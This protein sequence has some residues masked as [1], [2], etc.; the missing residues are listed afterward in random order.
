[1]RPILHLLLFAIALPAIGSLQ[2]QP[3][4]GDTLAR[5]DA[6]IAQ[7]RADWGVPGLAVAIVRGDEVLLSKGYGSL[8]AGQ[9][10][11]VDEHTLFAIA[12]NSKAFTAAALAMLADEGKLG[13]DDHVSDYL[14]WLK[15]KDPWAT[16]ELR[17]RDLLCHRSGLGTFS[18]DLL[19]WGTGYSAREVLE[20]AAK[21]EPAAPFRTKYEYSNLMFIAAGEVVQAASGLSWAEFVQQRIFAPLGMSRSIVSTRDLPAKGNYATPHKTYPG[22]SQPIAWMGWD[23]MGAAGGIISSAHDM[24]SW[25]QCQLRQGIIRDTLALFSAA[26]SR[27]MWQA[28]TPIPVTE[29]SLRRFP[30]THFRAYGL[31]WS[32]SDYHGHKFVGH[33]GGYD[34]MYSQVLMVPEKRLGVVVL[35]NSM[36]G[37]SPAITYKV[38]DAFLG[39]PERDWS[40]ENLPGFQR[41]LE[42]FEQRIAETIAPA[43]ADTRPS[44]P[45][46]A[47]TGAY[48]CPMY[49]DAQVALENGRLVL[50]LLPN[51]ELV[52]DLEHLHY[53]TFVARWRKD[54]AWFGAGTVH[55]VSNARGLFDRIELEVPN[56][57]LWFDEIGLRRVE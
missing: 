23:N 51:P 39:A 10:Q 44:R 32:L 55:F 15:L 22:R 8:E 2:A 54:F 19:W 50:R 27:E 43:A 31:G 53:D 20:R 29:G 56:D 35:T 26:Q 6:Y 40:A 46:E 18:G 42:R 30:T 25:M 57:D 13:W 1:M 36:T 3:A 14:P 11:P 16:A 4:T 5:L 12:S 33:G 28:H 48:R 9:Q 41:S 52:A 38:L 45:L 37:I 17:V 34:G 49:G 24:A 21:L 7:A 47:F